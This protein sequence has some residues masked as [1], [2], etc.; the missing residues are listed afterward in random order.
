MN[1]FVPLISHKSNRAMKMRKIK[2][3]DC[4]SL[5]TIQG[6]KKQKWHISILESIKKIMK[7]YSKVIVK[8]QQCIQALQE[9]TMNNCCCNT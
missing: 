3:F 5:V 7:L 6:I 1:H 9:V 2:Q 4:K 8:G